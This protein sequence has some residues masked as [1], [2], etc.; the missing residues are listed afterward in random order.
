MFLQFWEDSKMQNVQLQ[1]ELGEVKSD[2][3]SV[4]C[5]LETMAIRVRGQY[6]NSKQIITFIIYR[7][8]IR[9]LCQTQKREKNLLLLK[10][11]KVWSKN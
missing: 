7:R 3:E 10:S 11:L 1:K 6:S 8:S 5:Q 4:R 9:N 2:L